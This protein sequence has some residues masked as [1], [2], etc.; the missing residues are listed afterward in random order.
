MGGRIAEKDN[1]LTVMQE[2][3]FTQ[4]HEKVSSSKEMEKFYRKVI[5]ASG[6][7][8]MA[9]RSSR[10]LTIVDICGGGGRL[11][12]ELEKEVKKPINIVNVDIS[13]EQLRI[14]NGKLKIRGE[15]MHLPLADKVADV[16]LLINMPNPVRVV[17]NHLERTKPDSIK[18]IADNYELYCLLADA[19]HCTVKL[20]VFEGLRILKDNGIMSFGT[21]YRG[22]S[23]YGV[24][25]IDVP[26]KQ[27]GFEIFGLDLK[28]AKLWDDYGISVEKPEFF[29]ES[30]RKIGEVNRS[31]VTQC[32][33]ALRDS[34]E[35]LSG[36]KRFWEVIGE[37]R[38]A[39]E[40]K[41]KIVG[42][43]DRE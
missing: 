12:H 1:P 40:A 15:M 25:K 10:P 2:L 32:R 13:N 37:M 27:V 7:L 33:N 11:G 34:L 20:A 26:L 38:R 19:R 41:K 42:K 17:E 18:E 35:S 3:Y 22:P 21:V 30:F 24:E 39:E 36:S 9:E 8:D 28:V 5:S 16:A 6:V 29:V 31:S 14:D 43:I 4:F 23:T